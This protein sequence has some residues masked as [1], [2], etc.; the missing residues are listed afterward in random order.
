MANT[1]EAMVLMP[2]L[3]RKK[4]AINKAVHTGYENTSVV[5]TPVGI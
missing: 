1:I 4:T 5:A 3:S 2:N